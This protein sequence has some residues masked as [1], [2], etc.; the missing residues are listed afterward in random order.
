MSV[1]IYS[2]LRTPCCEFHIEPLRPEARTGRRGFSQTSS[3]STRNPSLPR[4]WQAQD[5]SQPREKGTVSR[6]HSLSTRFL[7]VNKLCM[8]SRR[9]QGTYI[10]LNRGRGSDSYVRYGGLGV[11]VDTAAHSDDRI[12]MSPT[13]YMP[14]ILVLLTSFLNIEV[15]SV[16]ER[17]GTF[18][19]DLHSCFSTQHPPLPIKRKW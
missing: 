3:L 7:D 17:H 11:M 2:F 5:W 1:V 8:I 19:M 12:R 13:N 6:N 16:S 14:S 9:H 10:P 4:H 18:D 15:T